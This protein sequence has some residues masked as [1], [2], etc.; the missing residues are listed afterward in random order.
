MTYIHVE[1]PGQPPGLRMV[2]GEPF[3]GRVAGAGA[4]V[5][6]SPFEVRTADGRLLAS[7]ITDAA[8]RFSLRVDRATADGIED[9]DRR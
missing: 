7:A 4:G 3:A 1:D 9:D 5:A 2:E 8:G 6:Y